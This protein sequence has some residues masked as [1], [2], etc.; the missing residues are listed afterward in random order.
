MQV[1]NTRKPIPECLIQIHTTN[2][3]LKIIHYQKVVFFRTKIFIAFQL[4][5]EF[6][7]IYCIVVLFGHMHAN[8]CTDSRSN[9]NYNNERGFY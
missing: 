9:F 1:T 4:K 5:L 3:Q 7:V 6:L 8:I 2:V